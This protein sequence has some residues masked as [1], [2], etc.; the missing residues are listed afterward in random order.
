MTAMEGRRERKKRETA[1]RIARSAA[2]LFAARGYGAVA[3][4][5]VAEAA[6]VSEQ[7]VYNHFPTKES[8]VFDRSGELDAAFASAL[9]DRTPGTSAAAALRPVLDEILARTATLP[10]EAQRGGLA[11]LAAREPSL[12]RAMLERTRGHARTI[13]GALAEDGEPGPEQVLAGWALAG[14][15]QYLIEELGAAQHR[16]EAP[17]MTSERLR[18]EVDRMLDA[19]EPL[20]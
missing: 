8:L 15:L 16:G 4:V 11:L 10:L 1:E 2:D 7:T 12:Q 5:D 19:V 17:P 9:R 13:A 6:D 20:G 14:V 3:V 18:V